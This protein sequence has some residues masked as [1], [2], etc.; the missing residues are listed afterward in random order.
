MFR[1]ILVVLLATPLAI[2]CFQSRH[3]NSDPVFDRINSIVNTLSDITGLKEEHE[4]PYGRMSQQ[5]LR[6][7]LSRRIKQTL[8]PKE[9][10]ADEL[11]LKLFGL[12][13]PDFDLRKSTVDLLTEQAAAFYDYQEKKLFLLDVS[14]LSAEEATLAHELAHALADQHFNLEKYVDG[15]DQT[16]DENLAHTAVVEGQASWLMLAYQHWQEG[17]HGPPT[18]AQ[19]DTIVKSGDSSNGDFPVLEASPLYIQ[20]SLLFPYTEGT[21]FFNSIYRKLGKA[22]FRTVF[23]DP[24]VDTAQIYHPALYA[25]HVKPTVPKISKPVFTGGETEVANGSLGEFD[26]HMLLWQFTGKKNA[27]SLSPHYR[28]GGYRV[29]QVGKRRKHS[30]LEYA[31]EWDSE[32]S[33]ASYFASYGTALRK[34]WKSC[35]VTRRSVNLLAGSSEAGY[36]IEQ[37]SGPYVTSVEGVPLEEDWQ[38][39]LN[40]KALATVAK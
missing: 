29:V 3:V 4:V 30:V 22:A 26:Q 5:Q 12:V 32:E 24:P 28:G 14:T 25:S 7:F 37:L 35:D 36:F 15:D 19:I 33:A 11:S 34:K 39:L 27:E 20:Q 10:Y 6:K 1:R 16:D 17:E 21:A 38:K 9:L 8:K 18:D 31:S 13:P 40:V 23:E 2:L